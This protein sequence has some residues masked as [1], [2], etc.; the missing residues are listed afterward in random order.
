MSEYP[1][2]TYD[3]AQVVK[4]STYSSIENIHLFVI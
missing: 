4:N 1:M 3:S 2:L